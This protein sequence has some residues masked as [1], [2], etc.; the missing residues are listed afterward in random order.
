LIVRK[1]SDGSIEIVSFAEDKVISDE[2]IKSVKPQE[3]ATKRVSYIWPCHTL[4]RIG[5][6]ALRVIEKHLVRKFSK[7]LADYI[8]NYARQMT[9]C[10][11]VKILYRLC[12]TDKELENLIEEIQVSL[13]AFKVPFVDYSIVPVAKCKEGYWY[14]IIV[15]NRFTD[16]KEAGIA[17]HALLTPVLKLPKEKVKILPALY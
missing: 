4:K 11:E 10:W 12:L 17:E 3:I 15:H 8:V 14:E 13:E 1:L 6:L 16:R 2:F 5:F 7:K 9:D